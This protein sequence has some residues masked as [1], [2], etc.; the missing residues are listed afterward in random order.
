MKEN[1]YKEEEKRKRQEK[2]SRNKKDGNETCPH[3]LNG[4]SQDLL[5]RFKESKNLKFEKDF[6]KCPYCG[7]T[8]LVYRKN[9][10]LNI[11][12]TE[13]IV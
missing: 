3:C 2:I 1:Q 10:K 4:L 13:S 6:S 9:N 11:I 7:N 12:D 5:E 8:L